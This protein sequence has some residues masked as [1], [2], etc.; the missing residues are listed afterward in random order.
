VVADQWMIGRSYLLGDAAHMMPPFAGQGLNSGIRDAANLAWK[1]AD[2]I[3][4]RLDET[5]LRTYQPERQPHALSTV[6]LSERLGRVVMTTSTR[7]AERRDALIR[8]ALETAEG[9]EFFEQMRYRPSAHYA[10]GLVVA[11]DEPEIVGVIVGQPLAFET[12]TRR[13]RRLDDIIGNRWVLFGVDVDESDWAASYSVSEAFDAP[14]IVISTRDDLPRTRHNVL[15]DVDTCLNREFCR[16]RG[17]FV[18][19]RPDRFVAAAWLPSA[20]THVVPRLLEWTRETVR[21][22]A[23]L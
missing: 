12:A 1:V 7:L 19:L 17:R 11:G 20:S 6:R 21:E 3:H 10:D 18:L 14:R 8:R 13:I 5:V 16:F 4:G 2:V 9:R 22:V 15:L 23:T